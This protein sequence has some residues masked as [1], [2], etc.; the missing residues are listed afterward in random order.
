[1]NA[2]LRGD[3]AEI[4]SS[5]SN[6]LFH[7]RDLAVK[8]ARSRSLLVRCRFGSVHRERAAPMLG[9]NDAIRGPPSAA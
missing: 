7:E 8:I 9:R 4:L 1:L 3:D 2:F 6:D 5:G